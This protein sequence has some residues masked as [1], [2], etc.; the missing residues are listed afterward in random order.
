MYHPKWRRCADRARVVK[1][2]LPAWANAVD[3]T[4]IFPAG[5]IEAFARQGFLGMRIAEEYG[6][7]GLELSHYCMA[8]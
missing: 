7:A 3:Q 5:L 4:G 6:G 8:Q 2:K 1:N